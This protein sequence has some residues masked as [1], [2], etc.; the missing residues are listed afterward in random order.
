MHFLI[1]L[2]TVVGFVFV[3][4]LGLIKMIWDLSELSFHEPPVIRETRRKLAT[5]TEVPPKAVEPH[6]ANATEWPC[7]EKDCSSVPSANTRLRAC[8]DLHTP[9]ATAG[10]PHIE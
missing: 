10:I 1:S 2:I 4:C 7:S 8:A 9:E 3:V 6:E 5:E